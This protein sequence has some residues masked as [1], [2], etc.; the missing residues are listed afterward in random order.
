MKKSLNK[1]FIRKRYLPLQ[2]PGKIKPMGPTI[3]GS[4]DG[5]SIGER[6]R[7]QMKISVERYCRVTE[8]LIEVADGLFLSIYLF[9][10]SNFFSCV[11]SKFRTTTFLERLQEADRNQ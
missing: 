3:T 2:F 6:V 4:G 11:I 8:G 7:V 5:V 10:A 9:T 1:N